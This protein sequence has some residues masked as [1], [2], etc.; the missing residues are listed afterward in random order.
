MVNHHV[1]PLFLN[2]A[3]C[4]GCQWV[5]ISDV[6]MHF[7]R[8]L[9]FGSR[10]Q[11]YHRI[12][13]WTYCQCRGYSSG[14]I[15][16]LQHGSGLEPISDPW[17]LQKFVY[18]K[19][20]EDPDSGSELAFQTEASCSFGAELGTRKRQLTTYIGPSRPAPCSVSARILGGCAQLGREV[21]QLFSV[22]T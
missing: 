5:N 14:K 3:F 1:L 18:Q 13:I 21:S 10:W 17:F 16:N 22:R 6:D 11:L 8:T 15:Q 7:G 2:F 4:N 20:S 12:R 9:G 19:F